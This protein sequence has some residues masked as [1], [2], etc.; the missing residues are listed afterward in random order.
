MQ[1]YN[2]MKNELLRQSSI[3]DVTAED[4][5]F[6]NNGNLTANLNWEGKDSKTDIDI[7]YSFVDYN[8]FDML[9]V[10]MKD[11]RNF[12]QNMGTDQNAFI[13]NQEAADKINMKQPVGKKFV[14]DNFEGKIIGIIKNTNFKSLK[15]RV[16]PTAYMLLNNYSTLSFISNGT[17]LV[18]TA[19]GKTHE[20]IAAI[21]NIWKRENPLL[22]F[23]YH[24]LDETIDNQYIKEIQTGK[25]FSFF[26]L[27]AIFISCLGLY[28]FSLNITESRIKEIGVRKVLGASVFEILA[29]L[30]R[31]FA[32]LILLA[33]L[34]AWP[35]A[36]YV[37]NNGL[38]DFA[39]KINISPWAFFSSLTLVLTVA[40][41][42]ISMHAIKA[43]TENPVKSLKYE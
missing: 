5:L 14:L 25:I 2:T 38:K 11:G 33:N 7:E 3:V 22:P 1:N 21:E 15:Y 16:E 43:A 32:G 40:L 23:E 28:G 10:E 39:Y 27:L 26:S 36:Y 37:M 31:D 13:L 9:N 35:I 34:V 18:K 30:F 41:L 29:L 19:A 42:T 24:F 4:R 8:Y 20:A 12:S 17:I 6:T